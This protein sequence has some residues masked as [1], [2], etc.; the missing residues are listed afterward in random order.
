MISIS[1]KRHLRFSGGNHLLDVE[2]DMPEGSTVAIMGSSGA[3]KTSM[4][5]MIAGLMKPDTGTI[6]VN[7][8]RWLDENL[9]LPPQK[10]EIGFVFQDYALFPHMTVGENL[11]FA[12]PTGESLQ[13][14]T[15]M[16]EWMRLD[17]LKNQKPTHLS[18][19]QQQRVALARALIRKPRLLLLDEP[20]AALDHTLRRE[21]Q[22]ELKDLQRKLGFSVILVSHDPLEV[23]RLAD[24]VLVIEDG[25]IVK[26]GT[27]ASI[28]AKSGDLLNQGKVIEL[29]QDEN[30]M[31]VL[32]ENGILRFP[33]HNKEVRVGDQM[34]WRLDGLA[35]VQP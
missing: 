24:K 34:Q 27:P 12:L 28:L 23:A 32:T 4:L 18:G 14:V 31:A 8:E 3:G 30:E 20:L 13:S 21:L 35:T 26:K 22:Y 17:A 9:N 2:F 1:L 5:R 7:G 11:K 33:M 25:K 16:L 29:F 15:N 19:G 10:R 6:E